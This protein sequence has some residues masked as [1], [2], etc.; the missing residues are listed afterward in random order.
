[1]R[2][3]NESE[4]LSNGAWQN[5][6]FSDLQ[7]G[8]RLDF[9]TLFVERRM[10]PDFQNGWKSSLDWSTRSTTLYLWRAKFFEVC[11]LKT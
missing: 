5:N 4:R 7:I 8:V 3:L 10:I 1:M 11:V 2:H 6:N 9:H